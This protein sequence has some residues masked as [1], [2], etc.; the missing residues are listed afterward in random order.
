MLG[1][2]AGRVQGDTYHLADPKSK[3]QVNIGANAIACK[4]SGDTDGGATGDVE[5]GKLLQRLQ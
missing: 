2:F 1:G 5:M 3:E 4:I